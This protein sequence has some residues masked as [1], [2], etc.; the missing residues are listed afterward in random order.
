MASIILSKYLVQEPDDF[1][2]TEVFRERREAADVREE[3]RDLAALGLE[4]GHLA[5]GQ[6]LVRHLAGDVAHQRV[7]QVLPL[8]ET[9]DHVIDGGGELREFV[10]ALPR[11]G[12]VEVPL[13]DRPYR[14]ADHR[15]RASQ[16]AGGGDRH[17]DRCDDRQQ[18]GGQAAE[19]QVMQ[20]SDHVVRIDVGAQQADGASAAV[21]NRHEGAHPGAPLIGDE[22]GGDLRRGEVERGEVDRLERLAEVG[23]VRP[24]LLGVNDEVRGCR[25]LRVARDDV[26][27]FDLDVL[28]PVGIAGSPQVRLEVV[29]AGGVLV[30]S[31]TDPEV[32]IHVHHGGRRAGHRQH[33]GLDLP[34]EAAANLVIQQRE[35]HAICHQGHR[36]EADGKLGPEFQ[37]GPALAPG[38]R[39]VGFGERFP[40]RRQ[41]GGDSSH[42]AWFPDC[43]EIRRGPASRG[44]R[45]P[46]E[47]PHGP[48][49]PALIQSARRGWG[50]TALPAVVRGPRGVKPRSS[51]NH[52][53]D[54][55][56]AAA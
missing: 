19:Q 21:A 47:I 31:H 30:G 3:D 39:N 9:G 8:P 26:E 41:S 12:G 55:L 36:D 13:P 52:E 45:P 37:A 4:L 53:R 17:P 15:Q 50:F 42:V 20:P 29:I 51:T 43:G 46:S 49:G 2:G 7:L 40:G 23:L 33:R 35:K 18:H 1:L 34:H 56:R 48:R 24:L 5:G 10:V 28:A 14:V 25:M 32:L 38:S 27:V 16:P 6:D 54:R 22:P 44:V 11:D